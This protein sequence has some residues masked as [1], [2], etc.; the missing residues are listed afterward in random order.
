MESVLPAD[1]DPLKVRH[2]CRLLQEPCNSSYVNPPSNFRNSFGETPGE[3]QEGSMAA[4]V[5]GAAMEPSG[6]SPGVSPREL[7][8]LE[9]G[10]M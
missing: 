10:F 1:M 2:I 6:F 5:M 3:K 7:R 4:P 9:G 8:D